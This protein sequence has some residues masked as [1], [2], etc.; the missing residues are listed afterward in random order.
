MV[1]DILD[2]ELA[3]LLAK[4]VREWNGR[5]WSPATSTNYSFRN[6]AAHIAVSK[7]G[8]DKSQFS[9]NDFLLLDLASEKLRP[10]YLE[11]QPDIRTSAETELHTALYK[12]NPNI[13]AVVHT[14]SVYDTI[15]SDA[16]F[17][18]GRSE[19]VLCDYELLKAIDGYQTHEASLSIPIFGNTQNITNLA[20]EFRRAYEQQPDM[21]GYLIAGHGFYTW[22]KNIAEAKRHLEA[23]Q[24]LLECQYKAILIRKLI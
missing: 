21:K 24:F 20:A 15:L 2:L 4:Y 1:L 23:F 16:F 11:E 13:G 18:S 5:G 6:D 19:L 14:H 9:E 3:R 8:V 7:S 17:R 10:E 22:G 12:V